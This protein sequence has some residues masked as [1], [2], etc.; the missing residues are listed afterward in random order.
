MTAPTPDPEEALARSVVFGIF[1][2]EEPETLKGYSFEQ[3]ITQTAALLRTHVTPLRERIAELEREINER[4]KN[5]AAVADT[6]PH[7][8]N[9]WVCCVSCHKASLGRAEAAEARAAKAESELAEEQCRRKDENARWN[10][11]TDEWKKLANGDHYSL[12]STVKEFT[13]FYIWQRDRAVADRATMEGKLAEA[14]KRFASASDENA[15][16]QSEIGRLRNGNG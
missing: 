10:H 5:D 1:K 8:E 15:A 7:D 16:L 11:I 4:S 12:V 14:E 13:E 2:V 3:E 9:T 6:C